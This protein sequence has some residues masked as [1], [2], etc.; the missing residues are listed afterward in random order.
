VNTLCQENL[1]QPNSLES[2]ACQNH[3]QK[4]PQQG[5][6]GRRVAVRACPWCRKEYRPKCNRQKFC[7]YSCA[8]KHTRKKHFRPIA[9][10]LWPN[11]VI[12]DSGCWEWRRSNDGDGYGVLHWRMRERHEQRAHRIAWILTFGEIPEGRLVC[13]KCDNPPCCN[14]MHLFLGDSASNN[15]DMVSKGRAWYPVG[16]LSGNA[17]LTTQQVIQ[18][19]H[20]HASGAITQREIAKM[21]SVG[22][23]AINKIVLRRRWKHV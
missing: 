20:L 19:R 8:A 5:E 23:R 2:E 3:Q 22:F 11:L 21:F 4:L 17:K 15:A 12:S 10:R 14:P 13:H 6:T 9:E 16:E 18:I 1:T 7:S